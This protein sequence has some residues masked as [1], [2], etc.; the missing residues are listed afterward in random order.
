MHNCTTELLYSIP[1]G[2][3]GKSTIRLNLG[4]LVGSFK[5]VAVTVVLVDRRVVPCIYQST[6]KA[7]NIRGVWSATHKYDTC[8]TATAFITNY[9]HVCISVS[10]RVVEYW[11]VYVCVPTTIQV[12]DQIFSSSIGLTPFRK[13]WQ[14]TYWLVVGFSTF[15]F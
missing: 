12:P 8:I 7:L 4:S 11:Y 14:A 2:T 5:L 3:I 13:T 15:R 9:S 10:I 1:P 6:E